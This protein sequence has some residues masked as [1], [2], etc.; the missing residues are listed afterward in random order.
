MTQVPAFHTYSHCS[1]IPH[2]FPRLKFLFWNGDFRKL[3]FQKL[4]IF[5]MFAVGEKGGFESYGYRFGFLPA[6]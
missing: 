6:L 2:V 5:L 3:F 1:F 4:N